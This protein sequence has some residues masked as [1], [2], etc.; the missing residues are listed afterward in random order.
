[1]SKSIGG[2]LI[3]LGLFAVFGSAGCG[4]EDDAPAGT[5]GSSS[6]GGGTSTGGGSGADCPNVAGSWKVT[7]HCQSSLV[8]TTVQVSQS[9]CSFTDETYGFT[10]TLQSNGTL[11]V[12]SGAASA[13][14]TG[15]ASASAITENC[16]V[17]GQPCNVSLT[18]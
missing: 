14:C 13:T 2:A 15:T 11:T 7:M 6:T 16:T 18:R 5:G 10:G 17:A 4:G 1:M 3:L 12:S 9:G 8:G